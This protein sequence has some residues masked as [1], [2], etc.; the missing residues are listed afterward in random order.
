MAQRILSRPLNS[1]ENKITSKT[2]RDLMA[3]YQSVPKEA[4]MLIS[5]GETKSET[6]LDRPTLA[7]YTMVANQLLNLDEVLNK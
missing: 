5:V 4:E 6:Y 1:K 7:A 3:H 2:L